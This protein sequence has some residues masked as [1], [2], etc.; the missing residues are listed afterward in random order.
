[1]ELKDEVVKKDG[2]GMREEKAGESG[3]V[4]WCPT[5]KAEDRKILEKASLQGII[6][7]RELSQ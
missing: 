5:R 3:Q 7:N 2:L 4:G 6:Q 1:V